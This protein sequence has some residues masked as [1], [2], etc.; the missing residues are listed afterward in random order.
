MPKGGGAQH[1]SPP[2][3]G[4]RSAAPGKPESRV[5]RSF[6]P[7][8]LFY[9][10]VRDARRSSPRSRAPRAMECTRPRGPC[11][12][13]RRCRRHAPDQRLRTLCTK[14]TRR[15][16]LRGERLAR[17]SGRQRH[18]GHLSLPASAAAARDQNPSA[19]R[20]DTRHDQ[21]RNA[22]PR[23]RSARAACVAQS[24]APALGAGADTAVSHDDDAPATWRRLAVA[25]GIELHV[26]HDSPAAR[27]SALIAMRE[28]VRA[29]LGREDVR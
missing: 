5:P 20:A 10:Y 23:W 24:L 17:S 11:D 26:R 15:P 14:C 21:K 16:L 7:R 13:T 27:D 28:A 29:A 6:P 4:P 19:R 8:A 1:A 2:F 22:R 12:G 9:P 3:A 25:D 18:G